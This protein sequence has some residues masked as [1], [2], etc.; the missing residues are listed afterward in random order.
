MPKITIK[1]LSYLSISVLSET[2]SLTG[3]PISLLSFPL[4]NALLI[5]L[6][7]TDTGR[8]RS[9][10]VKAV[11]SGIN[12]SRRYSLPV[13]RGAERAIAVKASERGPTAMAV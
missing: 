7:L 3:A 1:P 9:M 12:C 10:S 5:L 13:R 4:I 8:M 6:R 2:P 11:R